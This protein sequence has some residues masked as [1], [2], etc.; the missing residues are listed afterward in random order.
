MNPSWRHVVLAI[1]V[2][3]PVRLF[4]Q[5]RASLARDWKA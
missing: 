5:D 1:A 2:L 3:A 4:A